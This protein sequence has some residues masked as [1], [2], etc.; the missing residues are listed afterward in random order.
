MIPEEAPALSHE[1]VQHYIDQYIEASGVDIMARNTLKS[2]FHMEGAQVVFELANPLEKEK[3]EKE[4][5]EL[6]RFLRKVFKDDAVDIGYQ[7]NVSAGVNRPYTPKEKLEAMISKN[8]ELGKLR[9]ILGLDTD[10]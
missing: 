5:P 6:V 10:Y 1:T 9:D 2:Q 3:V 8:P 7:V 4:K